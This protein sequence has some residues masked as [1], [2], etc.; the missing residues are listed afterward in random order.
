METLLP[1][2]MFNPVF[3]QSPFRFVFGHASTHVTRDIYFTVQLLL[4]F[5]I[6][7]S[8]LVSSNI[9]FILKLGAAVWVK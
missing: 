9:T 7:T 5:K 8:C 2:F 3:H 6:D 1:V 4:C